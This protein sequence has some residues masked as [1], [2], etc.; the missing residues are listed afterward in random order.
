MNE[1][2]IGLSP[3]TRQKIISVLSNVLADQYV[4]CTKTRNYHWNVTGE[5]FA[6]YHKLFEEQYS[7]IDEDIDEVAER[8]RALGGKTIAT[9]TEFLKSARLKEHAGEFPSAKTMIGNLLTDHE[10]VIRNLRNDIE[11]CDDVDD[12]GTEDFL[13]QLMEKHE[14]TAWMLRATIEN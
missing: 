7:A 10:T 11:I 9:L 1:A 2:N 4:L 5:D 3:D 13:T 12:V 6:Q 14:K 8:I